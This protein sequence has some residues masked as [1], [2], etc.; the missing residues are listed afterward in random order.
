MVRRLGRGL[1]GSLRRTGRF[2]P[3]GSRLGE[4]SINARELLVIERAL[5]WFAPHLV[6]SSVAVFADNSTA[7]SYLR[8]QGRTHSSFLN[9]IAQRILCWAEVL[10]VMISPTVYHGETQCSSGSSFS[11][12]P[13]L[14]LRVDAEAGGLRGSVQ[15]MA[16]VDRPVCNISKSQMFDI[17]SPYHDH[18]ALGTDTL[19]QSWNGWQA[20][21]FPPWSLL[22]GVLKKLWSTSGVL[23]TI[24]APYWPQR[25][26]FPDLLDLVVDG[27]VALP[28]S[29]DLLRQPRFHRFH[30]GVSRL[31]L[32]AWRLSCDSPVPVDS[33]IV[34]LSRFP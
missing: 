20:Y 29:R 15:E 7:I 21:A 9:S 34:W 18:N 28:Q 2:R 23:L 3:L 26:W 12:R 31:C 33:P 19:F 8:I 1:G 5:L 17:F 22:P 4:L 13:N 11:P 24:I 27:P 6:G 32:H 10:S 14:G 25:P 30:L 16:G